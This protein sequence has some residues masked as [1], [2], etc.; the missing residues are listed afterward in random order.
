[1][2]TV[3]VPFNSGGLAQPQRVS[4]EVPINEAAPVPIRVRERRRLINFPDDSSMIYLSHLE[5]LSGSK[6]PAYFSSLAYGLEAIILFNTEFKLLIIN[7][8]TNP[9]RSVC[10]G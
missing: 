7:E 2:V 5:W 4:S 6:N 8:K 10:P 1:M 9:G 3:L